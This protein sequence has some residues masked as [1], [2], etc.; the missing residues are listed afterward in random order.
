MCIGSQ[1]VGEGVRSVLPRC[2]C[3]SVR[4]EWDWKGR[5]NKKIRSYSPRK[6]KDLSGRLVPTLRQGTRAI[7]GIHC[8]GRCGSSLRTDLTQCPFRVCHQ[9][10]Y[11]MFLSLPVL[12]GLVASRTS[13]SAVWFID[14][15]YRHVTG[16]QLP[17]D[18]WSH[19]GPLHPLPAGWRIHS[20]TH[21]RGPHK[22]RLERKGKQATTEKYRVFLSPKT[23]LLVRAIFI[24]LSVGHASS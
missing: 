12:V 14:S 7:V 20:F 10:S 19:K 24:K 3:V 9:R 15:G 4:A 16:L 1:E 6:L 17:R 18:F 21:T 2:E 13:F 23:D 11:C 8:P 5:S 22:G